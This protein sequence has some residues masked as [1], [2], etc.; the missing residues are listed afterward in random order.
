LFLWWNKI[1][2]RWARFS[3]RLKWRRVTK[4]RNA[5][6]YLSDVAPDGSLGLGG[7]ITLRH[8]AERAGALIAVLASNNS[9]EQTVAATK[10]PG[11]K[12]ANL[13]WTIDRKGEAF[14]RFFKELFTRMKAGTTMPRAWVAISP[15]YRH[16]AHHDLPVTVCQ[17]EAGQVRFR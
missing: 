7:N 8:L 2:L 4:Y 16:D 15:Q 9:S 1:V 6:S 3:R 13:V 14:S 11:P 12:R 17:L 5:A 10:F